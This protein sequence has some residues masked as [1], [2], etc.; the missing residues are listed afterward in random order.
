MFR[1]AVLASGS[2]T[3]LQAIID[4]LHR[5][6]EATGIEVVLV[7]SD[8]AGA[9]A[10]SR[11]Q[12]AGIATLVCPFSEYPDRT[13]HDAAMAK[14][15]ADRGADLVVLA[16]YMHLVTGTFLRPFPWRVINLHPALL[17]AFPGTHSIIEAIEYG[18]KVT[19]VTVHFVD[20][21]V[22]SGSI[23]LQ[24][25]LRVRDDDTVESLA[26]R[27]HALEHE[28]LT[29]AIELLAAGVVSPPA[30]GSRVVQ[31]ADEDRARPDQV[32][33]AATTIAGVSEED[34]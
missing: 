18:V 20:E 12:E 7:V 5:R 15:V 25:P 13:A 30:S 4:K 32:T 23:I 3:N 29:R 14:A 11:A 21:G 16:G 6:R 22:D 27:I 9:R 24:E 31:V 17:P 8:V 34:T 33:D 1:V 26:V 28:L 2:G 19:G 10:L